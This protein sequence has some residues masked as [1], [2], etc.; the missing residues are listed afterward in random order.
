MAVLSTRKQQTII[1]IQ[2]HNNNK[3]VTRRHHYPQGVPNLAGIA[4]TTLKGCVSSLTFPL[5]L[6]VWVVGSRTDVDCGAARRLGQGT[7]STVI[8]HQPARADTAT[9]VSKIREP[10]T[11]QPNSNAGV[12]TMATADRSGGFHGYNVERED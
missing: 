3:Q 9:D 7:R 6:P 8:H 2:T 1:F 5:K 11:M 10:N 4:N 12:V